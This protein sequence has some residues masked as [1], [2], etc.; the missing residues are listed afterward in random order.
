MLIGR[1]ESNDHQP[2]NFSSTVSCAFSH[3][4]LPFFSRLLASKIETSISIMVARRSADVQG[5]NRSPPFAARLTLW[6]SIGSTSAEDKKRHDSKESS[7]NRLPFRPR[8]SGIFAS[9]PPSAWWGGPRTNKTRT[10]PKQR[11]KGAG[12]LLTF[13]WSGRVWNNR[14]DTTLLV[15]GSFFGDRREKSGKKKEPMDPFCGPAPLWSREEK[16]RISGSDCKRRRPFVDDR[17]CCDFR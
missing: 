15:L 11:V 5:V 14:Y 13:S 16:K 3:F 9:A 1:V 4:F 6:S 10:V 12:L 7:E 8:N 17:S 2:M